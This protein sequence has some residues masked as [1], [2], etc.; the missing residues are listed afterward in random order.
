[1][2][3]KAVQEQCGF[4]EEVNRYKT[5]SLAMKLGH[6]LKKCC[7]IGICNSIKENDAAK[8][9]TLEDFMY[10]C[11]KEWSTTVSSVYPFF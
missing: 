8:R 3:V 11:D 6:S 2:L 4:T 5:P 7:A 10:L 9:Q 1:M